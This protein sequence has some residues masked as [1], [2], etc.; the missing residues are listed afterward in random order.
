MTGVQTCALPICLRLVDKITAQCASSHIVT[1]PD[2]LARGTQ[3]F[4]NTLRAT[5]AAVLS[6][7]NRFK[8]MLDQ[9]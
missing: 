2:F 8:Q 5:V 3:I 7:S 1:D 4:L 6:V 9:K